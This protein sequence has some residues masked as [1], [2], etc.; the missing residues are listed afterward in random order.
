MRSEFA[1]EANVSHQDNI[2]AYCGWLEHIATTHTRITHEMLRRL[3]NSFSKFDISVDDCFFEYSIFL[4]NELIISR[5]A[6]LKK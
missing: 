5:K 3:F 2:V 1:F 4:E 6:A